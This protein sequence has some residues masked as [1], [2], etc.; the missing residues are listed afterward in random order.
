MGLPPMPIRLDRDTLLMLGAN[1]LPLLGVV[2]A[3]WSPFALLVFFWFETAVIGIW[4]LVFILAAPRQPVQLLSSAA[5]P[6]QS[7]IGLGLF[8]LLHAGLF[9]AVHMF[10]LYNVFGDGFT[11]PSDGLVETL[12]G[13]LIDDGLWLPLFGLF[14][15][16]GFAT[17]DAIRHGDRIDRHLIGFYFRIVLMQIAIILGG[18]LGFVFGPVGGLVV[19]MALRIGLELAVPNVEDYVEAHNARLRQEAENKTKGG[20]G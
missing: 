5:H 3:G 15:I 19:L 1:I 17:V 8:I 10:F 2:F 9:M 20:A 4:M 14:L 16:R 13:L 18:M 12:L 11:R 6:M 7:G